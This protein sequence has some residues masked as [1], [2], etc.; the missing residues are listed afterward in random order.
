MVRAKILEGRD[1]FLFFAIAFGWS[2]LL[3]LPSVVIS[4]T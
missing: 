4:V 1:L 2:W 3:R